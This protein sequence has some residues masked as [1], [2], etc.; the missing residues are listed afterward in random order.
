[1]RAHVRVI[2]P[3]QFNT[4]SFRCSNDSPINWGS[5]LMVI[6][7][8]EMIIVKMAIPSVSKNLFKKRKEKFRRQIL[9]HGKNGSPTH[10]LPRQARGPVERVKIEK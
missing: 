8:R 10:F 7:Y 9:K 5:S 2:S 6:L 4:L 1:M 3:L